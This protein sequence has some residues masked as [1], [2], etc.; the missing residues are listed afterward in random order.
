METQKK[1]LNMFRLFL[2]TVLHVC[3]LRS[4]AFVQLFTSSRLDSRFSRLVDNLFIMSRLWA[5]KLKLNDDSLSGQRTVYG[6]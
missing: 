2:V 3:I 1:L 4:Y 6:T 5:L